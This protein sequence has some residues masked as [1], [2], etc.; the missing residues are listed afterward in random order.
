M[1]NIIFILWPVVSM[2][3]QMPP[4][5]FPVF[6]KAGF[7]SVLEFDDVPIRVVLGD[8]QSFQVEKADHTLVVRTLAPYAA[9]NMFVYFKNAEP[10]LFIL[11][12]SED[13]TT[14]Y[15]KKFE[16]EA[17]PKPVEASQPKATNLGVKDEPKIGYSI[18]VVRAE[19]D[20][21]K[22]Y[23]VIGCELTS[24]S[25]ET[26]KPIWKLIRLSFQSKTLVPFKLWA[27][28]QEVQKD[29]KVRFRLIFAK[30]NLP[31]DLKG[32]NIVVPLLGQSNAI[33]VSVK[34]EERK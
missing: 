34:K 31:R 4:T 32:V 24:Q 28:R 26:L 13:A 17:L 10:R 18:R 33:S 19:F 11:T 23:L 29:S 5:P 20:P 1:K 3:S 14:T 7:S 6:L 21:K 9:S 25:K 2:G 16:K 15:Y 8:S 30:P 27:E 22:D 12:A